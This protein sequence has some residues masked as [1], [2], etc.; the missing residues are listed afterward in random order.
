MRIIHKRGAADLRIFN[1]RSCLNVTVCKQ[2]I[3]RF[4]R[5]TRHSG[6][7]LTRSVQI[8]V[9]KDLCRGNNAGIFRLGGVVD[10][11]G[12]ELCVVKYTVR[13]LFYLGD[14]PLCG[15]NN[16]IRPIICG[17]NNQI[18]ALLGIVQDIPEHVFILSVF[19]ELCGK[20]TELADQIAVLNKNI[21]VIPFEFL[22]K[23]VNILCAVCP[24]GNGNKRYIF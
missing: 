11:S 4:F 24:V 15:A 20:N 5:F 21:A 23:S 17:R 6:S 1:Q 16:L 18:R 14:L 8:A 19:I 10:F 12:L 7:R 3:Y 9:C 2:I 22:K 13:L